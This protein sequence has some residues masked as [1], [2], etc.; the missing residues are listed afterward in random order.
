MSIANAPPIPSDSDTSW[1]VAR[2]KFPF[3]S[4]SEFCQK[5]L[6]L[7]IANP[8]TGPGALHEFM[9]YGLLPVPP[10]SVIASDSH[11]PT[12][13][14]YSYSTDVGYVHMVH[15]PT[16]SPVHLRHPNAEHAFVNTSNAQVPLPQPMLK[17]LTCR[18]PMTTFESHGAAPFG[19]VGQMTEPWPLT[20]PL[21]QTANMLDPFIVSRPLLYPGQTGSL[22]SPSRDQDSFYKAALSSYPLRELAL[23]AGSD[24]I[25]P[26]ENSFATCSGPL[27]SGLR[28]VNGLLTSMETGFHTF[29]GH[30]PVD[31]LGRAHAV[32]GNGLRTTDSPTLSYKS[33]RTSLGNSVVNDTFRARN[34]SMRNMKVSEMKH[35]RKRASLGGI[36]QKTDTDFNADEEQR[37]KYSAFNS[38][39]DNT[40]EPRTMRPYLQL[41]DGFS[42]ELYSK[43]HRLDDTME[44]VPGQPAIEYVTSTPHANTKQSLATGAGQWRPQCS[45]QIQL[46]QFL[47]ELLSDSRN[48]ACITWEGTNG[49][50]KLVDPDE[51]ARRWGERKSKP[52]MN[53][54]KLSR[55]LRYYYDKNIMSKINGKRYAYKFDFTGLAQAMQSPTCGSPPGSDSLGYSGSQALSTLLLP[56]GHGFGPPAPPT[57]PG[58]T[59]A[60]PNLFAATQLSAPC[61][62]TL[63]VTDISTNGQT[64]NPTGQ[65]STIVPIAAPVAEATA[66]GR[67]CR[68]T[69][70]PSHMTSPVPWLQSPVGNYPNWYPQSESYGTHP[71]GS[72]SDTGLPTNTRC[73]LPNSP[74]PVY[75]TVNGRSNS[76]HLL[77]SARMAAAAAAACLITPT[78]NCAN[79]PSHYFLPETGLPCSP[80][81]R[82]S[83]VRTLQSRMEK[84]ASKVPPDRRFDLT[85]SDQSSFEEGRS[86]LE[87]NEPNAVRNG[88]RSSGDSQG[89]SPRPNLLTRET[90]PDNL[91]SMRP[92]NGFIQPVDRRSTSACGNLDC[93]SRS[94]QCNASN[95]SKNLAYG[96]DSKLPT[97][98]DRS[99]TALSDSLSMCSSLYTNST[100]SRFSNQLLPYQ[101]T[102]LTRGTVELSEVYNGV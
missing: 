57:H 70:P 7:S 101:M 25:S 24:Y 100:S 34:A 33:Y 22:V 97:K 78:G 80:L 28:G 6:P 27:N 82:G 35:R 64:S 93:S 23:K 37:S 13:A 83:S 18:T 29:N 73:E 1:P 4:N 30:R 60:Y 47:L 8:P 41:R 49:E 66:G 75:P 2:I 55:A 81:R 86:Q 19:S 56:V 51:V 95:L 90:P 38:N 91:L 74:V 71:P 40:D 67:S 50:F 42:H 68:S 3:G 14:L 79:A 58:L 85:P 96:S 63:G 5:P 17:Q 45:G 12:G 77:Q 11:P 76:S 92:S 46:W 10:T 54:D 87:R 20:V 31:H 89:Q 44:R 36:I 61:R 102:N 9:H 94:I 84:Y 48:I 16:S 43:M 65:S 62:T 15:S 99:C 69:P 26:F 53:Y 39:T 98:L 88:N 72:E 21:S 52:N 59:S 32:P